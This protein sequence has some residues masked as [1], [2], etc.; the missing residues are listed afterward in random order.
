[1]SNQQR[2]G[3]A[4]CQA[5]LPQAKRAGSGDH[6]YHTSIIKVVLNNLQSNT[7]ICTQDQIDISNTRSCYANAGT[8]FDTV[9]E[10]IR[11]GTGLRQG[12]GH[13]AMAKRFSMPCVRQHKSIPHCLAQA[14]PMCTLPTSSLHNCRHSVSC[15]QDIPGQMVLGHL[16]HGFG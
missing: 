14:L 1:L 5:A 8:Q 6:H 16:P 11:H 15:H 12:S 2:L 9:T 13:S 3:L 7:Y 10:T 4:S